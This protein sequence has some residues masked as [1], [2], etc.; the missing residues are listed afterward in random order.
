MKIK[1]RKGILTEREKEILELLIRGKSQKQISEEL[2]ISMSTVRTHIKNLFKKHGV[3]K[4]SELVG[5]QTSLLYNKID[6]LEEQI[7][8]LNY[9]IIQK[10]KEIEYYRQ[11]KKMWEYLKE[12]YKE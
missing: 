4:A 2:Y 10:D 5:K 11:Y 7:A 8:T 9:I 3:H 12:K 1:R 6:G